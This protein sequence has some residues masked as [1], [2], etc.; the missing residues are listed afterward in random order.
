MHEHFRQALENLDIGL[1]R[2]MWAH[3]MPHLPQPQSDGE[4]LI[5]MHMARTAAKSITFTGRAYSHAW[6]VE[7]GLPSQL[8]DRLRPRAERLCPR[9][10]PAVGIAVQHRTP[11]ALSIRRAMEEAVLDAGVADP[12]LTKRAIL[13][14]R[15]KARRSLLGID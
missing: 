8:P 14:A 15:T 13:S 7:R 1:A 2:K 11:I 10:V 4:A 5:G 3:V 12:P 9:T 6:L